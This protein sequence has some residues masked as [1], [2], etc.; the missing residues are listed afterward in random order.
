MEHEPGDDD[1]DDDLGDAAPP[2]HWSITV[3]VAPPPDARDG[4]PA[5]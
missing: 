3:S 5:E 2:P 1:P 4:G